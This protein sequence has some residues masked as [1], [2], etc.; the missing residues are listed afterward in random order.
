MLREYK[1]TQLEHSVDY[2]LDTA[3]QDLS[4]DKTEQQ[5]KCAHQ[6]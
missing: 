5:L 6:E 4:V 2:Y 3:F 1:H